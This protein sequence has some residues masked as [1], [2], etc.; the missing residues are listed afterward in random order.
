[1]FSTI[2]KTRDIG[3]VPVTSA[4]PE[5]I[6]MPVTVAFVAYVVGGSL[7]T[8]FYR[9]EHNGKPMLYQLRVILPTFRQWLIRKSLTAQRLYEHEAKIPLWMCK[10][11]KA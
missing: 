8:R 2:G 1:M 7:M 9:L 3:D 6:S 11:E 5:H 4:K 10:R